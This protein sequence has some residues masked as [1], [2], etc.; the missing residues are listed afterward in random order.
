VG[1]MQLAGEPPEVVGGALGAG[2]H[3]LADAY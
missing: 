2:L 3:R 1:R